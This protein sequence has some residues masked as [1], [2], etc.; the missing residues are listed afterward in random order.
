MTRAVSIAV[1]C[2]I[3]L[4]GLNIHVTDVLEIKA[5]FEHLELHQSSYGDDFSSFL[6]KHYG[7]KRSEHDNQNKKERKDH[8]KL[9]FKHKVCLDGQLVFLFNNVQYSRSLQTPT[10][11]SVVESSFFQNNY[12]FLNQDDIFQPPRL[13]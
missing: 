4:Q 6:A 9:P 11:C 7:E 2:L 10:C 5:L 3:L 12:S 13:L 8:E 1:S